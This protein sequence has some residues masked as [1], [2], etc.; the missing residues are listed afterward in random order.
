MRIYPLGENL[1]DACSCNIEKVE[2]GLYYCRCRSQDRSGCVDTNRKKT[3]EKAEVAVGDN[4]KLLIINDDES[5][6]CFQR[7]EGVV[8]AIATPVVFKTKGIIK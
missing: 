2:E 7:I 3:Y 8:K 5:F 4:I 1:G 6:E